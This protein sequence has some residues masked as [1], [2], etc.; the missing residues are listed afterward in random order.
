MKK[1]VWFMAVSFL[2]LVPSGTVLGS[3]TQDC[4]VFNKVFNTELKH[5]NGV[6]KLGI[7]RK[8]IKVS[9]LG[10]PLSPEEIEF[11]FGANFEKVGD[12][13]AVIGE[14]ALLGNEVNPVIDALRKGNINI[15]A[16]HNHLIGEEPRILFLHFQALGDA[17]SLA[18]TVKEAINATAGY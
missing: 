10:V 15:S 2:L 1:I 18:R 5:E 12:K 17:E 13:T 4:Q 16:L 11:S 14:F 8:N 7:T 6:C 9:N 3:E